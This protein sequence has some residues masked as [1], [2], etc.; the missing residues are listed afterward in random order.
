MGKV[1]AKS[2]AGWRHPNGALEGQ[3]VRALDVASL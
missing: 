3:P 1:R 2:R